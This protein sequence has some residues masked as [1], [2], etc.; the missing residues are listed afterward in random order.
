MCVV[1][2]V[3]VVFYTF[4]L[5]NYLIWFDFGISYALKIVVFRFD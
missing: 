4:D 3:R 2:Q 1:F 5:I